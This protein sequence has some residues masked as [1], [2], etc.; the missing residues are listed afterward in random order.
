MTTT[1][2]ASLSRADIEREARKVQFEIWSQRKILWNTEPRIEAMFEPRVVARFLDLEYE[3]RAS[4]GAIDS[5]R[6]EAAGTLDRRRGVIAVSAKF[7]QHVQR[8]TAAHEIGHYILHGWLG[9]GV[10]HRDRPIF[11]IGSATRSPTEAEADYFAA[12]LLVPEKLLA[13]E[14]EARFGTRRPLPLT[15]T[16]AWHLRLPNTVFDAKRDPLM[17]A[18]ALARARSF[19]AARFPSLCDHFGVSVSAMAIRLRETGLVHD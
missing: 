1:V 5:L 7:D 12:C 2:Q 15:E 17:F 4:I 6:T 13:T 14:F 3:I 11:E 8:F 9:Y 16:I 18:R 19:D 10:A